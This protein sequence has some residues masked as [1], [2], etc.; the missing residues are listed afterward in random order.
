MQPIEKLVANV[1]QPITRNL[2]KIYSKKTIR[3]CMK[4]DFKTSLEQIIVVI[5]L[6]CLITINNLMKHGRLAIIS[7]NSILRP[8]LY[9]VS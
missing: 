8:L 5:M 1:T 7:K 3:F 9:N 2:N 4:F 6:A